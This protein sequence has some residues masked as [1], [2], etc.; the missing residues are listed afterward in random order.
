[1]P[2]TTSPILFWGNLPVSFLPG[3]TVAAALQRHGLTDLG[4]AVGGLHGRYFC[5]VGTCQCCLVSIHGAAPVEA[6]LTLAQAGMQLSPAL[7]PQQPL[8]PGAD[9]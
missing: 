5:G 3:E 4:E 9:T 1:M 7:R 6:C 2:T 8:A